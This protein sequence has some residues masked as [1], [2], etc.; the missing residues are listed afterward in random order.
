MWTSYRPALS[1]VPNKDVRRECPLSSSLPP[2]ILM[3]VYRIASLVSRIRY[4]R[5][6][7]VLLSVLRRAL[8]TGEYV[9]DF[10][11]V[12]FGVRILFYSFFFGSFRV[13]L[14]RAL[15]AYVH[16]INLLYHS[17]RALLSGHARRLRDI[18]MRTPAR[19]NTSSHIATS[20]SHDFIYMSSLNTY[21]RLLWLTEP[22]RSIAP[23]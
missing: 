9:F 11:V 4:A 17:D 10:A 14:P 18:A 20:L 8:A 16:V 13:L 2:S 1:Q 22:S 15:R 7:T 23:R 12:V 21:I 3:N 6:F 19:W 5:S